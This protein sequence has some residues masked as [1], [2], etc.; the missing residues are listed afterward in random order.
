MSVVGKYYWVATWSA[1]TASI[2]DDAYALLGTKAMH[3]QTPRHVMHIKL[4]SL[5]SE[6]KKQPSTAR[7][8]D[9]DANNQFDITEC[10][11][12]NLQDALEW[13]EEAHGR[14]WLLGNT[15]KTVVFVPAQ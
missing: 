14:T 3:D 15:G 6:V 8:V 12:P 5:D 2:R 1:V 10:G 4:A 9:N 7:V 13:A 11:W